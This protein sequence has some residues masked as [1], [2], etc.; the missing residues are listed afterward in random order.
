M[1]NFCFTCLLTD[2]IEMN[3][4]RKFSEVVVLDE[5]KEFST[6]RFIVEKDDIYSCI[7]CKYTRDGKVTIYE[8]KLTPDN[9][10][11]CE[12]VILGVFTPDMDAKS[13]VTLFSSIFDNLGKIYIN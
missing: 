7:Q 8:C 9:I 11:K 10:E 1:Y 6:S 5:N 12:S 13:R 3:S 4:K 2:F